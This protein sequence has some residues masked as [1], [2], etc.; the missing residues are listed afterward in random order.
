MTQHYQDAIDNLNELL[1]Q[2]VRDTLNDNIKFVEGVRAVLRNYG[3]PEMQET[4]NRLTKWNKDSPADVRNEKAKKAIEVLIKD[5]N[6]KIKKKSSAMI[7][8]FPAV[9]AM[10]NERTT[11]VTKA[12]EPKSNSTLHIIYGV[13]I[14]ILVAAVPFSYNIGHDNGNSK[15][16]QGKLEL[17]DTIN[18]L[19]KR[20]SE[21]E[22]ED[23][24]EMN[25]LRINEQNYQTTFEKLS[26]ELEA[27]KKKSK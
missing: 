17:V 13:V 22:N 19:K 3:D 1:K 18:T 6:I 8:G 15:F 10:E 5:F 14:G 9:D 24:A 25:T 20:I 27:C 23:D 12:N 16:D 11:S 4:F 21:L 2:N 7:D 26:A